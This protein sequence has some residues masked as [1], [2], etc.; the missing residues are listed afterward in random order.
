ML[1]WM[2]GPGRG[3]GTSDAE[4]ELC[5]RYV[6]FE[7]LD[8]QNDNYARFQNKCHTTSAFFFALLYLCS[9]TLLSNTLPH[10]MGSG[11]SRFKVLTCFKLPG[12]SYLR[13]H[14]VTRGYKYDVGL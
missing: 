1:F 4:R 12:M 2:I 8:L 7:D 10:H 14:R 5:F 13:P 11:V 9:I 6:R 3:V